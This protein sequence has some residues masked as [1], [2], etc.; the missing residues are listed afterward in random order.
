MAEDEQLLKRMRCGDKGALQRIYEKYREDLFTMAVSLLG[1]VHQSEDC[2]QE[3]FVNFAGSVGGFNIRHNLK[4]Y[5]MSCVANKA[6]DELRSRK[7][8][9]DCPVESISSPAI[10]SEP[11][12]KLIESEE[13]ARLFEALAELPYEQR[14]VFVLYAQGDMKFRQIA[15]VQKISIRTVQS[16]YRYAAIKLRAI[17]EKENNDEA[18]K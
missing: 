11:D 14:E 17:L 15:R 9:R 13:A 16:R 10:T 7:V 1:D 3:V 12:K 18:G 8:Y 6:R 2:L 4:G 5:L